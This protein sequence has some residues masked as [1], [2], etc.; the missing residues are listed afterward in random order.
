MWR[1]DISHQVGTLSRRTSAPTIR[2]MELC[3]HVIRYLLKT[4]KEGILLGKCG[5]VRAYADA[6]D[7]ED[8][9]CVTG[10]LVKSGNAPLCWV[11][12]QQDIV[13]LSMTEAEYIA[14]ATAAQ[15]ALWAGWLIEE[16]LQFKIPPTLY[17]DSEGARK[18]ANNPSIHR[19]TKHINRRYHFLRERVEQGEII[20]K[21][22]SGKENQAD[23]LTKR[24]MG[25][26]LSLQKERFGMKL[27][28]DSE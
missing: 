8:G 27:A 3:K 25:T 1:P 17:I 2:D 23:M 16:A 18:L 5:P 4:K 15:E 24:I 19:R 21:W 10:I 9:K 22:I 11:S 7:E 14:A 26:N 6:G 28:E 12:R 13:T 20:L